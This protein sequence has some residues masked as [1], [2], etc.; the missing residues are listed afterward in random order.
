MPVVTLKEVRY[1]ARVRT[2]ITRANDQMK[3]IGYTEHG[4][5]H[6]GIVSTI[7][8]HILHELAFPEREAELAAIAA[9]LH[10]I[11]CIVNRVGHVEA[12][13]LISYDILTSMG[14][15][16]DEIATIVGAIGNHEEP[17]GEPI[18]NPSAA[19]I[20]ADKS[21]V[22]F[23]R[24][25]NP[26]PTKFDIH[27][28]VNQA[29][30]KSYLRVDSTAKSINLELEINTEFASVTEYFEI[31]VLRMVLCR[32]AADFLGCKFGLTVNGVNL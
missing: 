30:Q 23:T 32:R 6:A 22:H 28:R 2:Y 1:D 16:P 24:V 12:G 25:Q 15:S 8:R 17:E 14:M 7:A 27:D 10:D 13:A 3:A 4:H 11:G 29:V 31:F 20:I 21:D 18:S 19:V 5:R 9:Y 26:D